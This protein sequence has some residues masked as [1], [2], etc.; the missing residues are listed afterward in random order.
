[1]ASERMREAFGMGKMTSLL[2][3][4]LMGLMACGQSNSP[5]L[6]TVQLYCTSPEVYRIDY[7][8]SLVWNIFAPAAWLTLTKSP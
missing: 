2:L 8:A 5:D 7:V 4:V 1:M 3:S 6:F